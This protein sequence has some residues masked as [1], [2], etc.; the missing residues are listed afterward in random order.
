MSSSNFASSKLGL[1]SNPIS[2]FCTLKIIGH[3]F[4][5]LLI[6]WIDFLSGKF[7]EREKGPLS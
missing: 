1:H 4:I 3:L 5:Y 2:V 6:G 7:G